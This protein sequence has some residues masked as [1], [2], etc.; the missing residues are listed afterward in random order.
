MQIDWLPTCR[1]SELKVGKHCSIPVV[2]LSVKLCETE[3]MIQI[4]QVNSK[5][6]VL[7][8]LTKSFV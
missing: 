4:K 3:T 6:V 8:H 1:M 5:H 7:G 2:K